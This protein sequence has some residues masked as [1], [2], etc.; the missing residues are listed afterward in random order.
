MLRA[1]GKRTISI[2]AARRK[3]KRSK[4]QVSNITIGHAPQP[5]V[6]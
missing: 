5:N 2:T 4:G 6:P 3:K 1:K